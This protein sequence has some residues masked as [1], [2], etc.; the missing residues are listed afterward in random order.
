MSVP[1]TIAT[2]PKKPHVHTAMTSCHHAHELPRVAVPKG[3]S[4]AA[5]VL[6]LIPAFQMIEGLVVRLARHE[7]A[8]VTIAVAVPSRNRRLHS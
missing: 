2:V 6:L 8:T 1:V 5:G 4:H 3:T 7:L